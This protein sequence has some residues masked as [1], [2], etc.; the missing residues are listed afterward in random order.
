MRMDDL[1]ITF[2][3]QLSGFVA[4]TVSLGT[5]IISTP[6]GE[7]AIAHVSVPQPEYHDHSHDDREGLP[8]DALTCAVALTAA[9]VRCR[10]RFWFSRESQPSSFTACGAL[11]ATSG[12]WRAAPDTPSPAR[13]SA[14]ATR[15]FGG[16]PNHA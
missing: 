13:L 4:A 11:S 14:S 7:Q 1:R 15:R 8:F 2:T 5:A 12:F 3:R 10:E 16:H 6:A 9:A